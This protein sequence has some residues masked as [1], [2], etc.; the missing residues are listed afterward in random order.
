MGEDAED[1]A[2]WTRTREIIALVGRALPQ[3]ACVRCGSED[4]YVRVYR[5]P[6]LRPAFSTDEAI[7]LICKRCGFLETHIADCL[8]EAVRSGTLPTRQPDTR[9]G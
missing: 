1:E 3:R 9:N 7:D 4:H 6:D 5:N 2:W 8:I